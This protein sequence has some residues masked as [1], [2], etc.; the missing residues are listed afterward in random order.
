MLCSAL[1]AGLEIAFITANKLRI[2]LDH[3]QGRYYAKVIAG[4]VKAPSRFIATML[5]ANNIALV[6]YGILMASSVLTEERLTKFLP[7][8]LHSNGFI[9]FTQTLLSTILILVAAE[10]IPKSLFRINPNAVLKVLAFPAKMMYHLLSP[11]VRFSLGL[12]RWMLKRI[13]KIDFTEE[14]PVFGKIDLDLYI[15]ESTTKNSQVE[16]ITNEI[17][18][19][20]NAL[21]FNEVRVKEC[22]VPRKEMVA[23]AVDEDIAELK[24]LFIETKL[25]RILVYR[26]TIDNIIGFVHSSEMLKTTHAIVDLILPV[27][28]VPEVMQARTLLNQFIKQRK[29]VAIVVDEFGGTSGLLTIEDLMEEI[30]GEIQDEHDE[31]SLTE[32][33]IDEDEYIFSG[34]LEVD[35]INKKYNLAL[36]LSEAYETLNGLLYHLHE[37]IPEPLEVINVPPFQFTVMEVKQNIVELVRLKVNPPQD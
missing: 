11:L 31:A 24:K 35:Y 37:N 26:D 27:F 33:Q 28:I 10:F 3:K 17:R 1:A 12:S 16:E 29:S 19:F 20:Q 2:E 21:D 15:R 14:Q 36:P 34:R 18:I 6:I 7:E 32:K 8:Q 5:I 13:F 4:F 25:S 30:F 22:M 9:Y 23:I